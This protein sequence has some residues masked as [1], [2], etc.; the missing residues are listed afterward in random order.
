MVRQ[1]TIDLNADMG[2]SFGPWIMGDDA[3]LLRIISSANIACGFHAGDPLIM[4]QTV[5]LAKQNNV[6]IGA[7]PS[8]PDLQGFGRRP[9][10]NIRGLELQALIKYQIGALRAIADSVGVSLSHVKLHGALA[11]MATVSSSLS[12]D[13]I[14]AVKSLG[15]DLKIMA[16][17]SGEIESAAMRH[18]VPYIS[19]I[20]ADRA[21]NDDGTLVSRSEF[22]SVITDPEVASRRVL[23]IL[24][25]QAIT[26]VNG[27]KIEVCVDSICVH[28]DNPEAVSLALRLR[29]DLESCGIIICAKG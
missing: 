2:E 25:E 16:M 3:S 26:S 29:R 22:G 18:D 4:Q 19:E 27:R 23:Q 20:F 10:E 11:N 13:Y 28:G 6:A 8:F 21:Y 14:L 5:E 7:H 9:M 1:Q 12:D 24:D 15:I 17:A